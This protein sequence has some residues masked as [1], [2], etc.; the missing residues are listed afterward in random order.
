MERLLVKDFRTEA[1]AGTLEQATASD[2]IVVRS[3]SF[4]LT[5]ATIKQARD[6]E[7][8]IPF[9]ISTEAVD[10]ESDVIAL[11]GW[12]LGDFDNGAGTVLFS[13][14]ASSAVADPIKTWVGQ[15]ALRSL[16]R[17]PTA[18][19]S[20]FA[21]MIGRMVADGIIKGASVGF[22]PLQWA[23]NEE[24]SKGIGGAA[25]DFIKQKLIEWSVTPLPANPEALAEA[26]K[27]KLYNLKLLYDWAEKH[28]SCDTWDLVVEREDIAAITKALARPL[29]ISAGKT[30]KPHD[31][32]DDD[33]KQDEEGTE[34]QTLIFS[35]EDFDQEEAVTWADDHDFKSDKVDETD[36]SFRLRQRD[37]D[38]FDDESFRTIDIDD[39]ITAVVGLLK[40]AET[41]DSE[42]T[43]ETDT[44]DDED[45]T[46]KGIAKLIATIDG[47]EAAE[48]VVLDH[49]VNLIKT[50]TKRGRV[51][52]RANEDKIRDAAS[53]LSQVLE[54]L[55]SENTDADDSDD[56]KTINLT[57]ELLKAVPAM[58][59]EAIKKQLRM[60]N[61]S[62]D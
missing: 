43:D 25:I 14:D 42:T 18:E 35:K 48:T 56:S 19:V 62:L 4:D 57:P 31:D 17:F 45:E 6:G 12:D 20:E 51:L 8:E 13:H 50:V 33:D 32:D 46:D 7:L 60:L 54:S 39:G 15:N 37:P 34:I 21:N 47:A 26:A 16:A 40:E 52:S 23:V 30:T 3:G 38:E 5:P 36:D 59:H 28:L 58:V 61:G 10:R 24:R 22:I 2:I 1:E 49:I 9:K 44:D 55:P 41:D 29:G 53:M 27:S 11:D